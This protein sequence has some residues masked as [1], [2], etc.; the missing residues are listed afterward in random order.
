MIIGKTFTFE[1]AHFL[2][3]H[4]KC[5][6]IHGHTYKVTVEV[7][8]NVDVRTGM[9]MDLHH[10]GDAVRQVLA[11]L[12]HRC[13]N[14]LKVKDICEIPT[15]ENIADYLWKELE[16]RLSSHKYGLRLHSLMVQEGEGGYARL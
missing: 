11:K 4:E 10:L 14:H 3:G 8:G 9:V 12:D 6:Y 15:C 1:A 13:L 2:P 16:P 7:A 5:G